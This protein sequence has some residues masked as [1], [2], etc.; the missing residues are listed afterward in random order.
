[1]LELL[2]ENG[3][4]VRENSCTIVFSFA[5]I[6]DDDQPLK[7]RIWSPRDKLFTFTDPIFEELPPAGK[8]RG[9]HRKFLFYIEKMVLRHGDTQIHLILG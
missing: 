2:E 4:T 1:M 9:N 5:S 8:R 6:F 7:E 3:H